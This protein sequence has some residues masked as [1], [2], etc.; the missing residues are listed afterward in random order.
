MI[1]EKYQFVDFEYVHVGSLNFDLWG[2]IKI[3]CTCIRNRSSR[4]K[5]ACFAD[6]AKVELPHYVIECNTNGY[7][8]AGAKIWVSPKCRVPRDVFR[9]SGYH[10]VRNIDDAQTIIIPEVNNDYLVYYGNVVVYYPDSGAVGIYTVNRNEGMRL[11]AYYTDL[12][13]DLKRIKQK[14]EY[15]G[16]T[17]LTSDMDKKIAVE[18]IPRIEEWKA[19]LTN[20]Y[21]QRNYMMELNVPVEYPVNINVE[22]L[23][24]WKRAKDMNMLAKAIVASDWRDYPVTLLYLLTT[25]Q[26]TINNY[27]GPQM[28]LVLDQIHYNKYESAE[29]ILQ[30]E[31]IQPKDWNMLQKFIMAEMG[32]PEN[33]GY[34]TKDTFCD[35]DYTDLVQK[36][37][38]IKPLYISEPM[39]FDNL[40]QAAKKS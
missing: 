40:M 20:Q 12:D 21:P 14:M 11:P 27:G 32:L 15:R 26:N 39:L 24:L 23:S 1:K 25:E 3:S 37:Y 36:R 13:E 17:I 22:T 16:A 9:N 8:N 7:I 5:M 35:N 31:M 28:K 30:N 2:N 29:S 18:L 34:I 10:I 4:N 33:G 6:K 38:A 19:L